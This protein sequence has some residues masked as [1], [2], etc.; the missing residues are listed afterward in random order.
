MGPRIDEETQMNAS[1]RCRKSLVSGG[2]DGIGKEMA[3]GLAARG[4][5]L[6]VVGSDTEKGER[7]LAPVTVGEPGAASGGAR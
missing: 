7:A 4:C 1:P 2:T 3:R 5:E 6:L